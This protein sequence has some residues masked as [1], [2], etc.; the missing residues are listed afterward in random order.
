[1]AIDYRG[2]KFSGYNKPK[3]TPGHPK[4]SHAV[5]AKEGSKVKLIRFGQQGVSG[6]PKKSGE[7][8][9]Y[10]KRRESFKARHL[11]LVMPRILPRARCLRLTGLIE[12]SGNSMDSISLPIATVVIIL[13]QLAGGVWFG[14]DIASRVAA[15]ENR[16]ESAEILPPG[17]AIKISEMSD[18]LARIETKLEILMETRQ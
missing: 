4:K 13:V 14:A 10:R 1:M 12:K 18:R 6:S 8:S 2:E 7:S 3:R 9:S 17:S 11:R 16:L 5:L 15:V